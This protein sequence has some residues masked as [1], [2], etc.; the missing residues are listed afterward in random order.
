MADADKSKDGAP[1]KPGKPRPGTASPPGKAP[2]V[3]GK[4]GDDPW[5]EEWYPRHRRRNK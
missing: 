2:P 1:E 4:P 3:P 5:G